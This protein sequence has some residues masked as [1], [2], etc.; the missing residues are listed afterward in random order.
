MGKPL[1][2]RVLLKVEVIKEKPK[3][4][5]EEKKP[6]VWIEDAAEDCNWA[7]TSNIGSEVRFNGTIL[8]LVEKTEDYQLVLTH[9]TNVLQLV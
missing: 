5:E 9:E 2:N 7:I 4:G 8:E 3:F 1:F 6:R